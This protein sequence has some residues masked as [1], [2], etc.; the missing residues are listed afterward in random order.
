MYTDKG[1]GVTLA[2]AQK[3]EIAGYSHY[4]DAFAALDAL[5]GL[6]RAV[7]THA[8]FG[9]VIDIVYVLVSPGLPVPL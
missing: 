1:D 4:E 9:S 2:V 7:P 8:I 6:C 5:P 3:D